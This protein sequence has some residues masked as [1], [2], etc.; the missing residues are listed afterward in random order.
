MLKEHA[1]KK[2]GQLMFLKN[3]YLF[4]DVYICKIFKKGNLVVIF[5][6]ILNNYQFS[7]L[8]FSF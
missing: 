4:C 7:Y 6:L 3:I 8:I 1:A 2:S 5:F